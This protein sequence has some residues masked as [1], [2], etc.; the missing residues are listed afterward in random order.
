MA[1][2]EFKLVSSRVPTSCTDSTPNSVSGG[3]FRLLSSYRAN[4]PAIDHHERLK[5]E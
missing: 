5:E 3:G 2:T 4:T 1:V